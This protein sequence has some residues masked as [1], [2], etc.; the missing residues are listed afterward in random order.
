MYEMQDS[1]EPIGDSWIRRTCFDVPVSAVLLLFLS[2]I[3]FILAILVAIETRAWPIFTQRRIG[4]Y[5]DSFRMYKLRTMYPD[6]GNQPVYELRSDPRVTRTGRVLR[7]LYVDEWLQL[8]NVLRGDM[9]LVGP[10]PMVP[11]LFDERVAWFA[12]YALRTFVR[13]GICGLAQ[14]F[15]S[16]CRRDEEEEVRAVRLQFEYD[17]H[18]LTHRSLR[19]D[20]YLIWQTVLLLGPA[21]RTP[22]EP[23]TYAPIPVHAAE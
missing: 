6:A 14:L 4:R 8:V 5:G 18:Y 3:L 23:A 2:P 11:W 22:A 10:R 1:D 21:S 16:E 15:G 7:A 19:Y 12:D 17:W 13:P 9:N 20:L